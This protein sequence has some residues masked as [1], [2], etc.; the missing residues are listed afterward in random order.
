MAAATIRG[1]R[2]PN[3]RKLQQEAQVRRELADLGNTAVFVFLNG[4]YHSASLDGDR[5]V[6]TPNLKRPADAEVMVPS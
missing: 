2:D 4:V 3:T 5:I 6:Y 1:S